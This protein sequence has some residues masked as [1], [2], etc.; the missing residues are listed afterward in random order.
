MMPPVIQ[1][2]LQP[3]GSPLS[4]ARFVSVGRARNGKQ[5]KTGTKKERQV[6]LPLSL[7]ETNL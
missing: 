7:Y 3:L 6:Y 4:R 1:P 5:V 2:K